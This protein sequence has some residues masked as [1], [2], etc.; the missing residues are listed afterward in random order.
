[1][2]KENLIYD[3]GLHTGE[4][5]EL[6]LKKGFNVIAVE[7]NPQLV[8][9]C[10]N[11][12]ASE[13]ANGSLVIVQGAIVPRNCKEKIVKFYQNELTVWGTICE[14]WAL[15]NEKLGK[16]SKVIEVETIHFSEIL[17][18]YGIPHYLKIDIE[19]VDTTCLEE[20]IAFNEKPNYISIE[21]NKVSFKQLKAEFELFEK[22][23]YSSYKVINQRYA[24]LQKEPL[25]TKE[26][27]Y[28]NHEIK[29]GSSGL[30]GADLPGGVRAG[31]TKKELFCYIDLFL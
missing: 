3:V 20:L 15:R 10:K 28:S 26:G 17:A 24:A 22:L 8:E 31:L 14:D 29:F 30:F 27:K 1:M 21:S 4:D 11:K 2:K 12:F 13:I 5:T 9:S 6:Y 23:G 19:G 7:A 16:H 18:K 25:N